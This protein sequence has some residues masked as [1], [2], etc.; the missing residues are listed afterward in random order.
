MEMNHSLTLTPIGR[1]Q[2]WIS[3]SSRYLLISPQQLLFSSLSVDV[4]CVFVSART[5][6]NSSPS[7]TFD[8]RSLSSECR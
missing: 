2:T 7:Q 4:T 5:Y 8:L 6:R 1:T 3:R